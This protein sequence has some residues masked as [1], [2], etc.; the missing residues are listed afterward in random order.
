MSKRVA[1]G[2]LRTSTQLICESK[3]GKFA[4]WCDRRGFDPLTIPVARVCDYLLSLFRDEKL[5]PVT[6]EG[7]RSA[8][9]S[10]WNVRGRSL[11]GSF[12]VE[13]LLKSF[14]AERPR[15]LRKFPR[16]DLNLVLRTLSR[17]PYHPVDL[18]NPIFHSSKTVFLLLLASA[19][20]RGDIH[21]I[22][23]NRVTFTRTGVVLE[24][25]PR[26]LPKVLATA[27]GEARYAPIVVKSLSSLTNDPDELSLCPV[28]ALRSYDAY[29]RRRKPNRERFFISTRSGGNPVVKST[30]SSWVVRLLR[31]AYE[32]ATEGDAALAATSTHEIRALAASLAMQATFS[33][34]D[35]LSAASWATPS[36]FASFY[37]R[38]VTGLQ[39]RLHVLGPCII[40]GK[41][42]Q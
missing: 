33:L 9:N 36:T 7:Y 42:F 29:A 2:Q 20:R 18:A 17:P 6:I 38:D 21:A 31:R 28:R 26:Y 39:G 10:V 16:W 12:H 37:L 13:Q 5:A 23:P 32:N 1:T 3:W 19:R 40:A 22:D 24:P 14:R 15:S 41:Q 4:V 25:T 11:A 30:I 27:E 34:T 35:V 8:I